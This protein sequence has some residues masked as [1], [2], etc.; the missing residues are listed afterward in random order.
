MIRHWP[1]VSNSERLKGVND[2]REIWRELYNPERKLQSPSCFI[3]LQPLITTWRPRKLFRCGSD[4]ICISL[5]IL[6]W[7]VTPF[8]LV[9]LCRLYI[10]VY[11]ARGKSLNLRCGDNWSGVE[12]RQLQVV[13]V[14][15]GTAVWRYSWAAG[16][17][18]L[19]DGAAANC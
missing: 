19:T 7:R 5:R 4:K 1:C 17:C 8:I 9:T 10:A 13:H 11:R 2:F 6:I 15:W 16:C 12:W 18:G 14:R 3:Y